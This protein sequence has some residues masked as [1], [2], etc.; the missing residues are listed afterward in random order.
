MRSRGCCRGLPKPSGNGFGGYLA[1]ST[2]KPF[3]DAIMS[4][5]VFQVFELLFGY[6]QSISHFGAIWDNCGKV[7]LKFTSSAPSAAIRVKVPVTSSPD[8]TVEVSA[9]APDISPAPSSGLQPKRTCVSGVP[10][11]K[12]V[13]GMVQDLGP[14]G[15]NRHNN[16]IRM[17]TIQVETATPYNDWQISGATMYLECAFAC[18]CGCA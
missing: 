17:P 15:C 13:T 7:W 4:A 5:L 6:T 9:S 14:N 10:D 3:T 18:E 8:A 2:G 12:M 1:R 11:E 16:K